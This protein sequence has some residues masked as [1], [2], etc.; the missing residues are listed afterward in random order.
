MTERA[1]LLVVDYDPRWPQQFQSL[2]VALQG[3]L[4]DLALAL[5]HVGS[6][7]VVGLAAK[8]VIDLDVVVAERDVAEGIRRLQQLGYRHEGDR[9]IP[10]REAFARPAGTVPHHLYLCPPHGPALA[11]H[12]ALRDHLRAHPDVV[13]AYGA[14]KR[15]LA[16]EHAGDVDAYV[17]GK[18]AFIVNIL[19]QQG[20]T[21]ASLADIERMNR[22]PS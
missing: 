20:F 22:K 17:E 6:T 2:R 1:A 11:N 7:A 8:P 21:A 4:A 10:L 16:R 18:T 13:R 15:R 19:R 14:L 12:L 9:G 5:E 3:A